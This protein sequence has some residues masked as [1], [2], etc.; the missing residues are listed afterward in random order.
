[1]SSQHVTYD[2]DCPI[3][4]RHDARSYSQKW[5]C[6]EA[7][8]KRL[9]VK[10]ITD[11][12]IALFTADMDLRCAQPILDAL[13][14]TVDHG[15]F[16][17]STLDGCS[18]YTDAIHGWFERHDRWDV[19]CDLMSLS[20]GT[21]KALDVCVQA[22]TKPGDGIII[23]RPVY[24]PFMHVVEDNDRMILNN[25]LIRHTA[26]DPEGD[27]YYSI[28]FDNLEELAARPEAKMFILCNPHNPVGRVWSVEELERMAQI[29]MKHDVLIVADEIHGD[30]VC[31]GIT[32]HHMAQVAPEA[33]VITC[34][35]VN[36]TFNL[37]GLAATN[38]FFSNAQDKTCFEKI[39]GFVEPNP[40]AISA[41][42]AAYNEGDDW[43][44]QV[45]AYIEANFDTVIAYFA[46]H[47]PDVGVRRPEGTYILWFDFEARCRK[48]G[49]DG[50]ELHRR[51]YD[52]AQVLLQD[53]SNFDPDGGEFFQR[54][55]VPTPR[56]ML[57][58]ACERIARV[59][60]E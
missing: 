59:L 32:M 12:H 13:H 45:K 47:L 30:L 17:Y 48:L 14:A 44:E 22:F 37:A 4:R 28:D 58:D 20:A 1:M 27:L 8:A 49:I 34:T 52:E 42:I 5:S 19:D 31:E 40:F 9:G 23:Q 21:V 41:V 35:A 36:K 6:S 39:R 43:Y 33:R 15:I 16:G 38:V 29:C 7:L 25:Q 11:N 51:I 57:L 55:C 18:A 50:A 54:M 60:A 46:D 3:D 24:P 10:E 2:F 26:K 56:T 53:G